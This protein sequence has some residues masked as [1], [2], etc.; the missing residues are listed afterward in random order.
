MKKNPIAISAIWDTGA[1]NSVITQKFIDALGLK[2]TGVVKT[3]TAAGEK[4]C[5]T[6][7]VDIELPNKIIISNLVVTAMMI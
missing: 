2:P 4:V 7:Y 3:Y 6:Y 5:P 1:T